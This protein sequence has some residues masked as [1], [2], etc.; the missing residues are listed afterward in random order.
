MAKFRKRPVVIEAFQWTGGPDQTEEPEWIVSAM[1]RGDASIEKTPAGVEMR[2]ETLEG[3]LIANA[4]NWIIKGVKGEIYPC[5]PDIFAATYEPVLQR[6]MVC[7]VDC[8]PG[9]SVCNNYCN[10][11]PQKGPMAKEPPPGPDARK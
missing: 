11:A 5:K 3:T 9:D 1:V 2:I 4:G 10:E 6:V 7:G 8:H